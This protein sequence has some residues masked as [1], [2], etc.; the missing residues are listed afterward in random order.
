MTITLD[1]NTLYGLVERSL[2]VI[3]KRSTD[4]DGNLLFKDITLGTNEQDIAKDFLRTAVVNI[5]TETD[6][7]VTGG[8]ND[9]IALTLDDRYNGGLDFF[10]AQA[11]QNY[12]VAYTLYSW[13]VVTA[14]RL[15]E[16]YQK[17]MDSQLAAI[18]RMSHN[19]KAPASA[20]TSPLAISSDVQ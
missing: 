19:K 8:N 14:P 17:D 7:F 1:Y 10:L 18:V 2:S 15:S 12:C 3:G 20:S 13:F 9:S 4:E 5:T 6:L 16:K 11:C